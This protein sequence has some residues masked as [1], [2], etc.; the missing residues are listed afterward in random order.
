MNRDEAERL[1]RKA[2]DDPDAEFRDGQWEAVD[3]VANWKK[4]L[5]VVQR[6]G[7]GKSL[8]YFLA[9]RILRDQGAGPTLIVSPLLALM[10]NQLAAAS[11]LAID[12]AT[13]N[14]TNPDDWDEII[15]R[16]R[17]DRVDAVLVSPERLA[18]QKF[19]EKVLRNVGERIGLLVID[20]AHCISDWGHDFRPDY[21]RIAN[22]L[23][24]MPPNMP[25]L[26]TTATANDRVIADTM[27][28]LGDLEVSRGPL[29]RPSL[30]LQ[31]IRLKDQAAR[32]AWLAEHVPELTGTGIIYVLTKRDAEQVAGW[33]RQ[34]GIE[35]MAYFS[36]VSV[37]GF[38]DSHAARLHLEDLLLGN[39]VKALVATTAL[40]MGYDKPDLGFVV[41]YQSP[42]SIVSYYQQVGRAGR[43]IDSAHGILLAGREDD[44][45]HEFFR[46]AAFPPESHVESIL[47]ALGQSDGLSIPSLQKELNLRRGEIE[48][49]LKYL[50]VETPGPVFKDGPKWKRAAVPWRMDRDK[51]ERLTGKREEEWAEVQSYI[52]DPGCH[53]DFLRRSLD[54]PETGECGR[55]ARCVG[56]PLVP[57]AFSEALALGAADYLRRLALPFHPRRRV[58]KG[59]SGIPGFS[60]NLPP[61]RQAEVG[62]ILCC[63][64]DAG[65]GVAVSE[66][67]ETGEFRDDLVAAA[68]RVVRESWMPSP[69]PEWIT[70]IPSLR[71]PDL[72]SSFAQRLA[73]RLGLPFRGAIRKVK[74]TVP[75]V[76]ME[77]SFHQC[78]NLDGVFSVNA[79][80]PHAP[81]LLVDDTVGSR[82]TMTVAAFLL[83]KAGSGKVYP[84]ALATTAGSG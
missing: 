10:R 2:L 75:Q 6:T 33:L 45:I 57:V 70:C 36:N 8:V 77:N 41:H 51:I 64:G 24:L 20:E 44:D 46:R 83:R 13:I 16:I 48:K 62:R 35:A 15:E 23:R 5:L 27:D 3:A 17:T 11:R 84:F 40:G 52:D 72:V 7:W 29:T 56:E 79:D 30:C 65:F 22:L 76:E 26:G 68:A 66:D 58:A 54:D 50:S 63:Y 21:R 1:L 4:K 14:S 59:A 34:N 47:D 78:R 42:G 12:A 28:Q 69:S 25:V 32:L 37:E 80:L 18:N 67:R 73:D 9:T 61:G 19:E 43:A 49:V 31:T 53:M 74:E 82:W 60:G 39:R 71:H 55:C 81:V 38:P